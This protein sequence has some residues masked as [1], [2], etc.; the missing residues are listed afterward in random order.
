MLECP[1]SKKGAR[2]NHPPNELLGFEQADFSPNF[3]M[4]ACL[5][6]GTGSAYTGMM[7]TCRSWRAAL[8]TMT[9]AHHQLLWTNA[10]DKD[11][12]D[13]DEDCGPRIHISAREMYSVRVALKRLAAT[14]LITQGIPV[15]EANVELKDF[16]LAVYVPGARWIGPFTT[17]PIELYASDGDGEENVKVFVIT[18]DLKHTTK[19][20]DGKMEDEG[21]D[22]EEDGHEEEPFPLRVCPLPY[23]D[24]SW[25]APKLAPAVA[26]SAGHIF[27]V[28]VFLNFLPPRPGAVTTLKEKQLLTYLKGGML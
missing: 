21:R 17:D 24:V 20:Y 1:P 5:C 19:L 11:F 18:P 16:L 14:P 3:L 23:A 13:F 27:G 2:N 25:K 28:T 22:G 12:A 4:Q 8:V 6:C 26:I 10:L 15:I 9:N 7:R